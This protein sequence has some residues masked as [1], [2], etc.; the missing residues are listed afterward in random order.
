MALEK[1]GQSGLVEKTD[2]KILRDIRLHSDDKS[3]LE[4]GG[5]N[6]AYGIDV[7]IRIMILPERLAAF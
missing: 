7:I 4:N 6:L 5:L 1:R 2:D 3:A